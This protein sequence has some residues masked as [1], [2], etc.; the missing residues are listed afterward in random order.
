[1]PGS[2]FALRNFNGRQALGNCAFLK[3]LPRRFGCL[4]GGVAAVQQGGCFGRQ[5][6]LGLVDLAALQRRKLVDL[7]DRQDR[8][9]LEKFDDVGVLG[10][11]PVLPEIIGREL[12]GVEPHRALGGL[13]HLV[14]GGGGEQR[15][16]QREQLRRAHAAA[17]VDAV[18]DVAPLVRAAHLQAAA[19]APR[20]LDEVV[21]LADHVVELD[22][23]HLLLALE[24]QPHRVHGQHAVDRKVPADIAQHLDPVQLGQ[25]FGIVEHDGVGLAVAIAQ[26]LGEHAADRGLVGLD[27]GDGAQRARLVLAGGIADHGGAAA[28]QRDRLVAALLQPVQQHHGEEVADMQRRRGAVI[29]DIGGGFALDGERVQPLE[30]GALVDEAAFL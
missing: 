21:G 23:A 25:P 10:V 24:A 28:H 15:R 20:Q 3:R 29:A 13:A 17:E 30:I 9:Q 7:A 6:L 1:M 11:A 4:I 2:K 12:V 27:L 22:E 5:H 19:G 18:D 26:H 14:A 8:E 16:G